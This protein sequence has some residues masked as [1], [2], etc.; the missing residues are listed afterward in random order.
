M[1][2]FIALLT[3]FLSA[4]ACSLPVADSPSDGSTATPD[5]ATIV[6]A[7]LT[8]V[9]VSPT[10]EPLETPAA[11]PPTS[12]V[13]TVA[14]AREGNLL[15][16]REGDSPRALSTTRLDESPR[17][18]DDGQVIAFLRN[19]ELYAV[20][21]DGAGERP[22]ANRAY[23]ESF[24]P[25]GVLEMRIQHF[26]FLPDSH[27]VFFSLYG[28]TEAYPQ[29]LNDLHRVS[30]DSGAPLIVLPAGQ[31]GGE[32][33]FSPDGQYFSLAQGN[34]IRVLRRDGSD[35]RVLFTFSFV[36]TYSE[37]T[38]FP[39]VVWRNDSAG[40]YTIIP[41]SAALENPREPTRYY[42]VPLTDGSPA[43]LAEFVT[44]PVWQSFPFIA[45]DGLSVAYVR[46]NSGSQSLHV[47][48]LSTADR[49]VQTDS[50]LTILNWN[51]D[52]QR[53]AFYNS[54]T[55]ADVVLQAF[56]VAP[57][58]LNDAGSGLSDLRWVTETRF[59]FISAG[60]LRLRDLSTAS[61]VIATTVTG[62]DFTLAP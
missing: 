33:T 39:E 2:R 58:S 41:A 7:T 61:F 62:Y 18:S 44:V 48:D 25:A 40:F 23:L 26:D 45:P 21:A 29:P 30:A 17:I 55:P 16:W 14:Y 59:L 38:Y 5:V 28:E 6:A 37:W 9:S 13:L 31:A 56:S 19:G 27:E 53:I 52:S 42:Y 22:L 10:P 54:N 8:A 60:E 32:W 11:P 43:Q 20:R 46:E 1:P 47:I 57:V 49:T 36:S 50:A 12:G 15:L 51:P 35:D 24:R 34:Q 4:L 3:L